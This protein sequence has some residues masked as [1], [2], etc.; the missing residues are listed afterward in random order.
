MVRS[1]RDVTETTPSHPPAAAGVDAH[2][3]ILVIDSSLA[4]LAV[5]R[6]LRD[7]LPDERFVFFGDLARA[8]YAH[9]S[10]DRVC[11][12]IEQIC[13]H[14]DRVRPKHVLLTCDVAGATA[15]AALRERLGEVA[16]TNTIDPAARAA[17]EVTGQSRCPTIGVFAGH[18]TIEHRT[19]ERAIIRRRTKCMIYSRATPSLEAL[20]NEGRSVQDPLLMLAAKQ[21]VEQLVRKGCEVIL[22]ASTPLASIR[23]LIQTIAGEN[24]KVVDA[25]RATAEDVARR[26]GR[27]RMLNLTRPLAAAERELE[28]F[29]SDDS[30][31]I[32][33][34]AER[35]AGAGLPRPTLVGLDELEPVRR[36]A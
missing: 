26:L 13:R 22:L 1:K 6:A 9:R 20:V 31:E 36:A 2:S 24:V 30:P 33:D 4:G 21:Y 15:A 8:P 34:R 28:W 16:V 7:R 12:F 25:T 29:L 19:L 10:P 32:F 5:V 14:V 23:R 35:L 11:R 27:R 18:W 17:V 3:P